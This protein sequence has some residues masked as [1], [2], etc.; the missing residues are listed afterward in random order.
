[1]NSDYR[2]S[3]LA[4]RTSMARKTEYSQSRRCVSVHCFAGD[5]IVITE[6]YGAIV[7]LN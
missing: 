3:W 1:M 5:T 4:G 2:E 6:Q 7:Y